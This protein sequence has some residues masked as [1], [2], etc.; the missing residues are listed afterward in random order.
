MFETAVPTRPRPVLRPAAPV[1]CALLLFLSFLLP[2]RAG[3]QPRLRAWTPAN[4]DSISAW[5]HEARERFRA[6]TGD[7]L[8]GENFRA[9]LYV[10]KIGQSL[11]ASLG[12]GNMT[13]APA[14]KTV[15]DS[16]GLVTA[17]AI[18]PT[19]PNFSLLMVRNPYRESADVTGFLYWY[20]GSVVHL[21]GVRFTSG[22][23]VVMRVWHT[24]YAEQ[25]FSMAIV[26][27]A[28]YGSKPLELSLLRMAGNGLFWTA[29]QYP[30]YGPD[31]G[32][33]GDAAFPDLNNDGV[34][35]LVTWTRAQPDSMFLECRECPSLL[36]EY[37]WAERTQGFEL[38]ETRV[39]P[40][41]YA[42]FVQFIRMLREG[43]RT[44]AARL[45]ADPSKVTEAIAN[46]WDKGRGPGLWR[47]TDAEEGETWPHRI[48]VRFHHGEVDRSWVVN[49]VAKD[50]RWIIRDWIRQ[51]RK[52]T[53]R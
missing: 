40:T 46:G 35:E 53:V 48:V 2:A 14:M 34:P 3:A 37:T 30:G 47:I 24:K 6:N 31:M 25:P 19:Q 11:L 50:G 5:A 29:A 21:Q 44:G 7:S 49:F 26:E 22:R 23:N 41:A 45:L 8:G 9:Y 32:G 10:G 12:R 15:I 42:N 33:R 36:T 4:M 18:D 43:N 1:F 51:E 38:E 20:V 39:V 16:L 27:N 52:V 17:I 28:H 13:Q